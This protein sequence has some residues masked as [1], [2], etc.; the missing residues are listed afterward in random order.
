MI[1]RSSKF[2]K[3]TVFPKAV[4]LQISTQ[5]QVGSCC[6]QTPHTTMDFN[7]LPEFMPLDIV[8]DLIEQIHVMGTRRITLSGLGDPALHPDLKRILQKCQTLHFNTVLETSTLQLTPLLLTQANVIRIP[9]WA[10]SLRH[11][12]ETC[13]GV[14]EALF[15]ALEENLTQLSL[16]R[17]RKEGFNPEVEIVVTLTKENMAYVLDLEDLLTES[18]VQRVRFRYVD[19]TT[20][21]NELEIPPDPLLPEVQEIFSKVEKILQSNKITSNL[22]TFRK[23]G[24][25]QKFKWNAQPCWVGFSFARISPYGEV[26]PCPHSRLIVGN[27][28]ETQNF[29]TIWNS[30]RFG[31]F[32]TQMSTQLDLLG[33]YEECGACPYLSFNRKVSRKGF[34]RLSEVEQEA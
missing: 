34:V 25:S 1:F 16:R 17:K 4:Q 9:L 27:I 6:R 32:C 12:K 5:R 24:A 7:R 30:Q 11:Q 23:E 8:E 3:H 15:H 10:F 26:R 13:L 29:E 28:F 33:S 20:A 31:Q 19:K 2:K 21:L 14:D 22:K 18:R